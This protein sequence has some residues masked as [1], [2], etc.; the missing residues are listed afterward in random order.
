MQLA[1]GRAADNR[2]GVS[3][4]RETAERLLEIRDGLVA[5][6]GVELSLTQTI[7]Y[8]ITQYQKQKKG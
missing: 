8:L 3:L 2:V 4:A 1:K 6:I 5:E 7:D